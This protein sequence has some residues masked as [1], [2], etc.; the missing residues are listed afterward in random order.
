MIDPDLRDLYQEIILDHGRN[1]RHFGALSGASHEAHGHN[2]LCGDQIHLYLK[3][4]PCGRIGDVAFEGKG[5]AISM[6]SAS[7][8]TDLILGKTVAEANSLAAAFYHLAKGEPA[9]G[10]AHENA[11]RSCRA[12]V[13]F[14][15]AS[16]A[17]RSPGTHSRTRA[18]ERRQEAARGDRHS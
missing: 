6:A 18:P 1:P 3:I 5:C 8:M 11:S 4:D 15:C 12:S 10:A 2:P 9:D 13:N 7:M 17:R 16:N 14:P